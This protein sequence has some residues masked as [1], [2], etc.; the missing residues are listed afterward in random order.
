[1]TEQYGLS[2]VAKDAKTDGHEAALE[3]LRAENAQLLAE[4]KDARAML[5][6]EI[7][8][9]DMLLRDA[10]ETHDE[11]TTLRERL[12]LTPDIRWWHETPYPE[13]IWA[14]TTEQYVAAVPDPH[15]RTAISGYLMRAGWRAAAQTIKEALEEAALLAAGMEEVR[16]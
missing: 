14:M 2:D 13:D 15:L 11:N 12:T 1:M 7:L 6:N 16:P 5:Q 3:S 8:N 4:L 9:S 10:R